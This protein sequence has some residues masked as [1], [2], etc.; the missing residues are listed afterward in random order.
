MPYGDLGC[1]RVQRFE[2]I[3]DLAEQNVTIE[4]REEY[5]HHLEQGHVV[6]A[7]VDYGAILKEVEDEADVI[8]WD[9][10]EQRT[11]VLRTRA[12]FR[13]H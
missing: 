13:S 8:L 9:G 2:T 7:G 10:G 1:Q 4:E 5:E 12:P 11:S 6:Y 3:A